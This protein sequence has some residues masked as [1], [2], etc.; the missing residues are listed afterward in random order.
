VGPTWLQSTT[1]PTLPLGGGCNASGCALQAESYTAILD[2]DNDGIIFTKTAVSN[3]L[4]G[5]VIKSPNG[6]T[7]SLPG[8]QETVATYDMTF[9]T[10]GTY[11]AYYRV[12]G[13]STS[14]DSIYTPDGFAT[15]PDNTLTATSDSTFL[16][17][18]DT[19]T[20]PIT[21][22]NL[23]V[24]LEFRLSMREQQTEIDAIVLNLNPSLI[25]GGSSGTSSQL[26]ALFA[27]VTGDYNG[28]HAVD[29]RDYLV[30]RKTIGQHVTAWTGADGNGD[31]VIDGNDYNIWKLNFGATGLGSGSIA[32][33]EVPE[34][35]CA[36]VT[37]IALLGV[38]S[39]RK[40]TRV[41]Y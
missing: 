8:T 1:P 22:G 20:F 26:D 5:Q 15:D 23:G 41:N 28:D 11:T 29:T 17:K 39:A 40:T 10:A 34:P 32:S 4:A 21:A 27:V 36:S 24:P 25:P 37:L 35:P 18:K 14:T 19:H 2:P 9:T 38:V 7:V 16:W 30:W 3:A 31:T 6:N 13:F 33:S 12:R